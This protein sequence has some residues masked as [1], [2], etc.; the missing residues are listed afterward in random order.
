MDSSD[1]FEALW[2]FVEAAEPLATPLAEPAADPQV[3]TQKMSSPTLRADAPAF[4]PP[5]GY[6]PS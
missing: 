6:P 4:T 1:G 2:R 3:S 5:A